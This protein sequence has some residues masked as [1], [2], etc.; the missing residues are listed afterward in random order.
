MGPSKIKTEMRPQ[1]KLRKSI[2]DLAKRSGAYI[3]ASPE[4]NSADPEYKRRLGAMEWS[5]RDAA[6]RKSLGLDFY[7]R[8]RISTWLEKHPP[9]IPWFRHK[10]NKPLTGWHSYDAW[11]S[12][13]TIRMSHTSSIK[14]RVFSMESGNGVVRSKSWAELRRCAPVYVRP[15]QRCD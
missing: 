10:V 15:E 2:G 4:S 9:L 8:T 14:K 6:G 1:G 5:V 13:G 11:S 7:D 3:I 12:P